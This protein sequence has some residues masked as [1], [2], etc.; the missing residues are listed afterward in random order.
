MRLWP[1]SLKWRTVL[2]SLLGLVGVVVSGWWTFRVQINA[3]VKQQ[4]TLNALRHSPHALDRTVGSGE[5]RV[6]ASVEEFAA[7]HPPKSR[8]RHDEYET[9]RYEGNVRRNSLVVIAVDGVIVFAGTDY[10]GP[11]GELVGRF[12]ADDAAA[13]RASIRRWSAR[14]TVGKAAVCGI[15][16]TGSQNPWDFPTPPTDDLSEAP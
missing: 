14:H 10:D 12:S 15:A 4:K 6:G 1:K 3:F 5:L 16:S 8:L 9:L 7:A 13:Y 2:L 11:A